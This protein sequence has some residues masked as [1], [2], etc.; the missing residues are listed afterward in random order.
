M[1][2][3]IR[4][5]DPSRPST[6]LRTMLAA[7][8]TTVA[9]QRQCEPAKLV[10]LLGGDLDWVVMKALEKDRTRRYESASG[11]AMEIRRYL[12]GDPVIARPITPVA[13]AWRWCRRKPALVGLIVAL[14]LALALGLVGILWQWRRATVSESLTRQNLYAADMSVAQQAFENNNFGR[15]GELLRAHWPE[16]GEPDLRGFEWRYLWNQCRGDNFHTFRGHSNVVC[17]VAFSPDG[18]TL[19]SGSWDSSVKLWDVA[20]RRLVTTL[21]GRV[22]WLAFSNDGETLATAGG[23]SVKLWNVNTH[24]LIFTLKEE[25]AAR[26]AFSPVGTLLAIGY[27]H[28]V[29]GD[30]VG[31]PIKLWDYV[32]HQ[33]VRTFPEPGSRLAFSPDGRI[34][35]ARCTNNTV[36]LWNVTTGEEMRRLENAWDVICLSFS[37]DGQTLATGN[38]AGEVQFWNIA[39]GERGLLLRGHTAQVWSLAFS[40]DGRRLATGGTDQTVRLWSVSS[41]RE[42]SKLMGHGSE[43]WAVAFSPDG[44]TLATGSKDEMVMLWSTAPKPAEVVFT[45]VNLPP[46]FSPD[47]RLLATARFGGPVTVWDVATRLPVWVLDHEKFGQFPTERGTLAT[48]STNRTLRFWDVATRTL[49]RTVLLPGITDSTQQLRFSLRGNCLVA[50][51]KDGFVTLFETTTGGL[52]GRL[53][54]PAGDFDPLT[55]SPEARLVAKFGQDR[56]IKLWDV[57][58]QKELAAVSLQKDW[59]QGLAFSPDGA[60]LAS[61]GFDG[62]VEFLRVATG[63]VE[64]PITGIKE[65]C[66]GVAFSPDGRTL[67][68]ACE[69][70][71]V[72]LWNLATRREVAVLKHGKAPLRFVVFSS[73]GQTLVSVCEHGTMR[74]WDAPNPDTEQPRKEE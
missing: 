1:R 49:Q 68:V 46:S 25:K 41:G 7:D 65:G 48:I 50:D 57:A 54:T 40:P 12:A 71:T 55:I 60:L 47:N 36:K 14:H 53:K 3:T 16:R 22:A 44:Q 21:P 64:S 58:T 18:K 29:F 9:T 26:I 34:L 45:N 43:V 56:S 63:R 51:D 74:F 59:I 10:H 20:N 4:E 27:G 19:A 69:D 30:G 32:T 11:L 17:C 67:A 42:E 15:G 24:Q 8:L 38:W 5:K 37:P 35:A 66:A 61:A 70:G 72:R 28:P 31:G 39:T 13:L 73:D 23:D 33:V 62:R 52:I 2:R 6:R